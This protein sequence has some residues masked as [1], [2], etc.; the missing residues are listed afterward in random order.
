M[1][2]R[3][4]AAFALCLSCLMCYADPLLVG[5]MANYAMQLNPKLSVSKARLYSAK[6]VKYAQEF[7]IDPMLYCALVARESHFKANA[8]SPA[9]AKGLAQVMPQFH[10]EKFVE[11]RRRFGTTNPYNVDVSLYVGAWIY[12]EYR[13]SS[14]SQ[15]A[16]L[17]KYNGSVGDR[18]NKYPR[19]I[20]SMLNDLRR[21]H[22]DYVQEAFFRQFV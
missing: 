21:H 1:I 22:L 12:S 20:N 9:G 11:A 16:A 8:V 7:S 4:I 17:K 10:M 15:H 3:L 6:I 2:Q 14:N 19:L 18:T 5:S 13:N